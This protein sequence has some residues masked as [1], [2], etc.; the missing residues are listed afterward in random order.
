M[1]L[2]IEANCA[3]VLRSALPGAEFWMVGFKARH[4]S[5][6][7]LGARARLGL[8]LGVANG[9][10]PV[11]H[12]GQYRLAPMFAMTFDARGGKCLIGLMIGHTVAFVA[13]I[14]LNRGQAVIL[15]IEPFP[16]SERLSVAAIAIV[17][18]HRVRRG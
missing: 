13:G 3:R 2:V 18:E 6:K 12:V 1:L 4:R 8:Q 15:V 10:L 9:A 11:G 5:R 7:A 17:V 14:V 16:C